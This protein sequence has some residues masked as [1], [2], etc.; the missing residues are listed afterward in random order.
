[1]K[2]ETSNALGLR[3]HKNIKLETSTAVGLR[4]AQGGASKRALTSE[5]VSSRLATYVR[6]TDMVLGRGRSPQESQDRHKSQEH[7][8]YQQGG[9]HRRHGRR[10]LVVEQRRRRGLARTTVG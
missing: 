2:V 7:Q 3:A 6:V 8:D 9:A 1:M 4:Q 5:V 10:D